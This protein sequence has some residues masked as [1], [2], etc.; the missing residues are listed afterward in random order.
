MNNGPFKPERPQKQVQK[1]MSQY[2]LVTAQTPDMITHRFHV[3]S[4]IFCFTTLRSCGASFFKTHK[5]YAPS[6]K[7]A[8]H[9]NAVRLTNHSALQE[10]IFICGNHMV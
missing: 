9:T 4:G 5:I 6:T 10:H 1:R 7:A 8:I 2:P 3:S